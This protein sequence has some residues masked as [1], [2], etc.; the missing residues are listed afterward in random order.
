MDMDGFAAVTVAEL[1]EL[2]ES[3][4]GLQVLDV[5]E[6]DEWAEQRIPGSVHV[7]YHDL[8]R[9]APS[10]DPS[11]PVAVICSTGTRSALAVGLVRRAG[12]G[13][14]IHVTPGGVATW[15]ELGLPTEGRERSATA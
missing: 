6:D 5:R 15:A 11:A 7:P 14:V 12:F 1:G 8:A 4:P 2:R 10:L 9:T 13:E 3:R